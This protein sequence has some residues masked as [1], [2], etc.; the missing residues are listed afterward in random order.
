MA[1]YGAEHGGH[2]GAAPFAVAM[3]KAQRTE[4]NEIEN[5]LA[6]RRPPAARRCER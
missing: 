5:N 6:M 3:A 2:A 1:A 4:I